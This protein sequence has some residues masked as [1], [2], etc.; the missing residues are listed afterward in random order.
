M[1]LN[2]TLSATTRPFQPQTL[3]DDTPQDYPAQS[4]LARDSPTMD[5]PTGLPVGGTSL[6]HCYSS[7]D[8]GVSTDTTNPGK[9]PHRR[10]S[11]RG[12]QSNWS[13]TDSNGTPSL[14]GR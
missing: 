11:S 7:D 8:D 2:P 10:H 9:P 3:M 12:N 6:H 4:R 1:Q 13:G 5:N 14:Q